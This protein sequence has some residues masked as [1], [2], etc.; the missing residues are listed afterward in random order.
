MTIHQKH[1]PD[2]S[3]DDSAKDII[4]IIAHE[5]DEMQ[6]VMILK[7]IYICQAITSHYHFKKTNQ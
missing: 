7:K 1:Y 4:Q 3:I 6:A 2:I 5:R